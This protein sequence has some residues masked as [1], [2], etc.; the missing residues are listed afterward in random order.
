VSPAWSPDGSGI[1]VVSSVR[2]GKDLYFQGI[3]GL[4]ARGEP[5]RLTT[6]LNIHGISAAN[7]GTIAY[8]VVNTRVGI[9]SVPIPSSGSVPLR[10]AKQIT[11]GSERIESLSMSHDGQWLAFDSDRSGNSDI[12]KM[13]PDGTGLE[14]LTRDDAD[15]FRPRWSADDKVISFHTWR[16]GTRDVYAMNADGSDQHLLVGGPAHEWADAWSPDGKWVA[17]MSDRVIRGQQDLY[18]MPAGGGPAKH[19]GIGGATAWTPDG[20]YLAWGSGGRLGGMVI[21]ELA[22]G[23]ADTI[24]SASQQVGYANETGGWSR[25]GKYLYFRMMQGSQLN[26]VRIGR[27]GSGPTTVVRFDD[28]NRTS[29]KPDMTIDDKNLYFTI[30]KHEADIWRVHVAKK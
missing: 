16:G 7:D 22:T 29:Y 26:I 5:Q 17:F 18:V 28:P 25:D 10:E 4:Q 1:F 19:I 9:W 2:G 20:K 24:F 6:G 12:Y 13:H 21:T 11:S 8:S 15:D 30:G 27:D 14:Q 23:K 3:K